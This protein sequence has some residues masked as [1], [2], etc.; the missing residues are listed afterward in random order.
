MLD[1]LRGRVDPRDDLLRVPRGRHDLPNICRGDDRVL[2]LAVLLILDD[3]NSLF[4]CHER[5]GARPIS[6]GRPVPPKT[7]LPLPSDVD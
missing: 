2:L 3:T 5:A 4:V 1:Q 6:V 7:R